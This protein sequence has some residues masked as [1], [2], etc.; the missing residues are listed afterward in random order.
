[1]HGGSLTRYIPS[2]QSAS[3]LGGILLSTAQEILKK[4][5][6]K[7][8]QEL[9]GYDNVIPLATQSFKKGSRRTL[10]HKTKETLDSVLG[11]CVPRTARDIFG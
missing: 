6:N 5:L 3:G 10:K 4:G 7:G 11:K 2:K 8:I 1:M 9:G